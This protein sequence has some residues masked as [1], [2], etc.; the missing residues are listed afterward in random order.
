MSYFQEAVE[1]VLPIEGG[2]SNDPNDA[3]GATNWGITLDDLRVYRHNLSLGVSDI[4]AL[5]QAQAIP[6]YQSLYWNKLN[7]DTC[8]N[9]AACLGIFDQAVNRGI[10]VVV[11]QVQ[12]VLG[13]TQDGSIGPQTLQALNS[14]NPNQ[15]IV[16]FVCLAQQSYIQIVL[17][18]P[19]QIE[20]LRGWIIRTQGIL[21]LIK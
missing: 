11:R 2:F 19:S 21:S 4:Q 17:N 15:F 18:K 14:Y 8:T 9:E 6:I 1:R 10:E 16:D 13:V 20:F 7:L 5:T 12:D 3:G